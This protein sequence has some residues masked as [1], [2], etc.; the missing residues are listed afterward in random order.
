MSRARQDSYLAM[1]VL[2]N[3]IVAAAR[4]IR[5][6]ALAAFQ[7][8]AASPCSVGEPSESRYEVSGRIRRWTAHRSLFDDALQPESGGAGY[9]ER[10][11]DDLDPLVGE[12][13][14]DEVSETFAALRDALASL[15]AS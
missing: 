5:F 1:T 10:P 13:E 15:L 11:E 9:F 12:P 14:Q 7:K 2:R 4:F 3:D 8:A 6:P